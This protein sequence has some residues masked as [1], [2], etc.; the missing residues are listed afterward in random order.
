MLDALIVGAGPTGLTLAAE[1]ARHG[2]S[3]RVVDRLSAPSTLS[4]A[5][6]LHSRTLEVL[7]DFGIAD[8]L[9]AQ[10]QWT[11]GL[12]L[13][14]AGGQRGSLPLRI[15]PWME[16]RYPS[17]LV[18][19]QDVTEAVLTEYLSSQGVQV[20]RGVGLEDF[21]QEADSVEATLVREGGG[22][23]RVRARWMVGCDGARSRVRKGLGLPFEGETYDDTCLLAD[24]RM[25]WPLGHEGIFL[26]L[27]RYGLMAVFP[28]PGHERF[29]VLAIMP[30]DGREETAPLTLE[31]LQGLTDR[32]MSVPVRLSEPGWMTRYRLHRRG[33]P[34]YRQGRVLVAGDA[35]H[36]HSP[37]GGQGMNTGMQDAYNL[38]WK[39][40]LV[41]KGRAPDS[42]VD[43][44]EQERLPVAH[45]LLSTTDRVFGALAHASFTSRL[46][47]SYLVP[48]LARLLFGN[49]FVQR[50]M[51]RF[52]SQLFIRY[53]RSPLSTEYVSGEDTGGVRLADGPAPGARV[54][55]VPV[56]GEGVERMYDVLRGP[57]HTLL[58][59][60]GL[61]AGESTASS[62]VELASRLEAQYGPEL[63]RVRVVVAKAGQALPAVLED[64]QGVLHRRFGAGSACLYLVRPDKHVGYRSRPIDV[65]RLEAELT[66]RMGPPRQS[67]AVS[68]LRA[69]G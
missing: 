36:I 6:G 34:R 60:A 21:R 29:R 66:A 1:L 62:L 49:T 55:D 38:A 8:K 31:E 12:N 63:L 3:C 68:R 25:E 44:Y 13:V 47:R 9:V 45:R 69:V 20:E 65:E 33:V 59:F 15:F 35:A 48:P 2:L 30:N 24:V 17:M 40:A 51:M 42:L 5:L 16:T 57:H 39:L 23:E 28:M 37:V 4:R 54:P 26:H 64:P 61:N 53:T 52:L 27:S 14:G 11:T 56:Q 50:R 46:L 18:V 41:T 22:V 67:Q 10:G 43:T 7:D 32:M 19:P 58:L